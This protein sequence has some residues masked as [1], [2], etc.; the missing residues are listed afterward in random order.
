MSYLRSFRGFH[1]LN[2]DPPMRPRNLPASTVT[3]S[4]VLSRG[5]LIAIRLKEHGIMG[6]PGRRSAEHL[7]MLAQFPLQRPP[8]PDTLSE[9]A[10]QIWRN[11][12]DAY[13]PDH[14]GPELLPMLQSYCRS[15]AT[16][17]SLQEAWSRPEWWCSSA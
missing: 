12:V 7:S 16:V 5:R 15:A 17:L 14:F 3:L 2:G 11:T 13:K 1:R 9:D 8:P 6:R 10:A 4:S